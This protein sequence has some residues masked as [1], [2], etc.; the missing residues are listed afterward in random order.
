MWANGLVN[1]E[2]ALGCRPGL[3]GLDMKVN[4]DFIRQMVKE[5]FGIQMETDMKENGKTI[6]R[7]AMG[8][9]F[10]LMEQNMK[11]NLVS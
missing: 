4:G 10:T 5:L 9:I 8:F 7:T 3:M 11:V 2:T 6:R 1:T